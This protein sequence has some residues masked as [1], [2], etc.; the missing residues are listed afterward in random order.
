MRKIKEILRLKGMGLSNRAIAR[1][2]SISHSTVSDLLGRAR[3]EGIRW[4]VEM[5][6]ASLEARLYPGNAGKRRRR[7]EPDW[8]HV[9][10]ELRR[11]GVTLQL[12]WLEYKENHPDGYQ[13][14]QF[15]ERYRRWRGKLDVVMRQVHRAGEKMF[16]K[17]FYSV[18]HSL[19][20]RKV[21][22]R[23]TSGVVE[24]LHKGRRVASHR[25]VEGKG[26]YV[27][28]PDHMPRAH[29]KHLE[30]TPSRLIRWAG[31]VGP[32]MAELVKAILKSRPH[33]EQGYRSCLGI[34]R[35]ARHYPPERMEA[36]ARRALASGALSYRSVKSIL[37]KG[38][39]K[40]PVEQRPEAP[41]AAHANIRGADY[42]RE[43]STC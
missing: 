14:S 18:P 15:C 6:E 4:P 37:A 8:A 28:D 20:R 42:Y 43:A 13:Y 21:D 19:V 36:A 17:S 33:P 23:V 5:D 16:V 11:K 3:A 39:D 25:R 38:L 24:V 7:P 35:L 2:L 41:V 1:S 31:T 27:T 30:W 22:V 40:Q 9:H 29:R 10:R 34:L 26:I 12:L 32:S